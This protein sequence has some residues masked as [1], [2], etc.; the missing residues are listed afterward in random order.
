MTQNPSTAE[1]IRNDPNNPP[2]TP[3]EF[4]LYVHT[5]TND[6]KSIIIQL[7]EDERKQQQLL[8]VY[9]IAIDGGTYILQ[10]T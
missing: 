5:T 10:A 9:N 8:N 7:D 2:R 4:D 1:T 6:S 3:K